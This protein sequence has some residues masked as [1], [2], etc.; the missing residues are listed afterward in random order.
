M[1]SQEALKKL[2]D[3]CIHSNLPD[4]KYSLELHII[5]KDLV[6]AEILKEYV[7][8]DTEDNSIKMLPIKKHWEN[9]HFE[10]LK[11]WLNQ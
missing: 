5:D 6:I 1:T 7:Y 2:N 9:F 3:E 10:I 11:E 4:D 8:L